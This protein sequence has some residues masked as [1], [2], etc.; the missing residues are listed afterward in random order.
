MSVLHERARVASLSR[1][2]A[3]DDPELIEARR[4]L[5]AERLAAFIKRN[6][7]AAPP[8]TAEQRARLSLLLSGGPDDRAT[9]S[10]AT[11]S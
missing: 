2:R 3:T 4:N 5:N 7:A 9:R 11:R 6:V 8:L 10:S 1:S